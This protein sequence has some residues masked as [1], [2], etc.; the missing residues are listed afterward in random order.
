MTKDKT[1][2]P[3]L[4]SLKIVNDFLNIYVL[5]YNCVSFIIDEPN[6]SVFETIDIHYKASEIFLSSYRELS[7]KSFTKQD[8]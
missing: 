7:F 1:I 6:L 8:F 3:V 5:Q 2:T 4:G